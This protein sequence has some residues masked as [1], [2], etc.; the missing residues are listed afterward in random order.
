MLLSQAMCTQELLHP[1]QVYYISQR[2]GSL[3]SDI[4]FVVFRFENRALF[5]SAEVI[6]SGF[7]VL[8]LAVCAMYWQYVTCASLYIM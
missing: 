7:D 8:R 3:L 2:K 6:L 5:Y 4:L 1:E